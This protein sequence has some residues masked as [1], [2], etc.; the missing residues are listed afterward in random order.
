MSPTPGPF[1]KLLRRRGDAL[2]LAADSPPASEELARL[3]ESLQVVLQGAEPDDGHVSAVK[4]FIADEQRKILEVHRRGGSGR[5][6]VRAITDLTDA[7]V[8]S[9]YESLLAAPSTCLFSA[10]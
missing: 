3:I 10:V 8:T 7:V 9:M 2:R 5:E 4:G 6:V 1:T